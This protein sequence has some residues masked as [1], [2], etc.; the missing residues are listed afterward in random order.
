MDTPKAPQ[1]LC[2]G[3]TCIDIVSVVK[4]F[5]VEDS[6]QRLDKNSMYMLYVH[7][8]LLSTVNVLIEACKI[9]S[10]EALRCLPQKQF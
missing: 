5:P 6:D 9:F 2:I 7:G 10:R 8:M 4:S 1:I 3:L